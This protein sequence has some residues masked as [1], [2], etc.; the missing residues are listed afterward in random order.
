MGWGIR[1]KHELCEREEQLGNVEGG[2]DSGAVTDSADQ[3]EAGF[4][5]VGVMCI[6]DRNR[7]VWTPSNNADVQEVATGAAHKQRWLLLSSCH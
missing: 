7:R 4:W 3:R 5:W 6:M 2:D 1:V